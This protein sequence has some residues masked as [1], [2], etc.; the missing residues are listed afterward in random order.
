MWKTFAILLIAAMATL[1]AACGDDDGRAPHGD[2]D[3]ESNLLQNASFEAGP[4]PW[5]SLTTEAWGTPFAVSSQVAHSGESSAYLELRAPAELRGARVF[6]VVQEDSLQGFPELLS[7]YYYVDNWLKGTEK[8]YLQVAVIVFGATNL[9]AG[10]PNY[11]IRYSLAGIAEEPF[12]IDNAR[13]VFVTKE[14]PTTGQWVYFERPVAQD[15]Q[16]LWGAVPQDFQ[17]L[18]ILF[19]VRYDDKGSG[20]ESSADVYYDDLYLGPAAT[21]PGRP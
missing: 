3:V 4:N 8:Q 20:A 5:F 21:N 10:V 11:Q 1:G 12:A 16:E 15:F 18:R 13:Y 19:E 9:P 7:G 2:A 6:G 14:E 17:N